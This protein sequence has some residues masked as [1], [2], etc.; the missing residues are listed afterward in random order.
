MIKVVSG[1]G[2]EQHEWM[3]VSG[4][5]AHSAGAVG[6]DALAELAFDVLLQ[7]ACSHFTHCSLQKEVQGE[8]HDVPPPQ[9]C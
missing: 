7:T 4:R 9:R 2:E 1:F 3:H 8:S 5:R 6:L